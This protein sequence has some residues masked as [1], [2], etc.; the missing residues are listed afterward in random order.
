MP[1]HVWWR[2][3]HAFFCLFFSMPAHVLL[4]SAKMKTK[5]HAFHQRF[6]PFRCIKHCKLQCFMYI[7]FQKPPPHGGP[8]SFFLRCFVRFGFSDF[9]IVLVL[10]AWESDNSI[11]PLS[12]WLS[13]SSSRTFRFLVL[14]GWNRTM[15]HSSA[16]KMLPPHEETSGHIWLLG[17]KSSQPQTKNKQTKQ[18]K[19]ATK[20]AKAFEV[21]IEDS[22]KPICCFNFESIQIHWCDRPESQLSHISQMFHELSWLD[23][24]VGQRSRTRWAR[25]KPLWKSTKIATFLRRSSLQ[26]W[27]PNPCQLQKTG[28]LIYCAWKVRSK[29]L[30]KT[31]TDMI[32]L[33][34]K[35]QWNWNFCLEQLGPMSSSL[36]WLS[37]VIPVAAGDI[38]TGDKLMQSTLQMNSFSKAQSQAFHG[39]FDPGYMM[40]EQ[41]SLHVLH[42]LRASSRY[43]LD[44]WWTS[45]NRYAKVF[46]DA[47]ET[48]QNSS[49]ARRHE[50]SRLCIGK[51]CLHRGCQTARWFISRGFQKEGLKEYMPKDF[52]VQF[53]ASFACPRKQ[54]ERH[55]ERLGC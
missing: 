9:A 54:A 53:F 52:L 19:Q 40:D 14:V 12:R 46:P 51:K 32:Q 16:M 55:A 34:S 39:M 6:R 5:K 15:A 44:I 7:F 42:M 43:V 33:K 36:R 48:V 17:L 3:C 8:L 10:S 25:W 23:F 24:V 30:A 37:L 26:T 27:H 28:K 45:L 11:I 13:T 31:C 4:N 22:R 1:V 47:F 38:D 49:T 29:S 35:G 41:A 21:S 2:S 18:I 20:A 50:P